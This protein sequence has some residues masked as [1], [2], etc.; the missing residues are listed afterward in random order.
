MSSH[1]RAGEAAAGGL[2]KRKDRE[3]SDSP[4]ARSP[5]GPGPVRAS[6]NRLLAG[7]L[8]HEFLTKGTLFGKRW[9][10]NGSEPDNKMANAVRPGSGDSEPHNGSADPVRS[11][12]ATAEPA[13]S[14]PPVAYAE[15]SYLLKADGAR[16]PGVVNPTQL[17][18]WLQM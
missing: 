1:V 12:G 6:D 17:A 16:L 4:G 8:A 15:V 10:P 11:G 5:A 3:P 7:C 13:R 2:R 9:E 18:R 14:K